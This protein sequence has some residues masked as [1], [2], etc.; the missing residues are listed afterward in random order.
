[1]AGSTPTPAASLTLEQTTV[2]GNQASN[3]GGIY[4]ASPTTITNSTISGN[5]ATAEGGGFYNESG[6]TTIVNSTIAF[7]TAPNGEAAGSRTS[8]S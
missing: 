2:S 6:T 1:M 5:T 8:T 4:T 3:G 7:N